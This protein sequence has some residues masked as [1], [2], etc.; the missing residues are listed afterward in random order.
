MDTKCCGC[1][2]HTFFSRA[3]MAL[4]ALTRGNQQVIPEGPLGFTQ[5]QAIVPAE[6]D[7]ACYEYGQPESYR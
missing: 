4:A 5:N 1:D 6:G 3:H 7:P 2:I